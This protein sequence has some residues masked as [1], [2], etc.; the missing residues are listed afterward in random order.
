MTPKRLVL[1]VLF[2]LDEMRH[3]PWPR[4]WY[5]IYHDAYRGLT[6]RRTR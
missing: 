6:V 3:G 4:H 5:A 2:A 1:D